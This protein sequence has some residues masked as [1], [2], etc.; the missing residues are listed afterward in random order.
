MMDTQGLEKVFE[1]LEG[2]YPAILKRL[3]TPSMI[4]S[5]LDDFLE[6]DEF[7]NLERAMESHDDHAAFEAAHAMK[8][9]ALNLELGFLSESLIALTEALRHGRKPNADALYLKVKNDY[10][11][12]V[13]II[14]GGKNEF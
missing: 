11:R 2:N 4:A 13:E 12:T 8:G 5:F 7:L 3:K 6:D 14:N 1:Q 9:V 10:R